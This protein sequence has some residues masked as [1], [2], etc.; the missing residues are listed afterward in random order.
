MAEIKLFDINLEEYRDKI[1][2]LR[3]ELAQLTQDTAE[4]DRKQQE[5]VNTTNALSNAVASSNPSMAQLRTTL[6]DLK[7]EWANAN[8]EAARGA[9]AQQIGVIEGQ[10]KIMNQE[11]KNSSQSAASAEGSYN[12]LAVKM[13]ELQQAA[14]AT[15]DETERLNLSQKANEINQQLKSMDA[16]MGNY[17]RNVGDYASQFAGAMTQMGISLGGA[18]NAFKLASTAG[19]GFRGVL[20]VLRAHPI[21]A[22]VTLLVGIFMKLKDAISKN[23]ALSN[24]WKVAMSAFQP[25]LNAI[26]NAIDWLAGKLV[27][28][29]LWVST[30]LPK[31]LRNVGSFAKGL[32]NI[33]GNIVDAITFIPKTLAKV[34]QA[35]T[36]FVFKGVNAIASKIGD[37]L[38]SVGL[39]DWA[40]KVVNASKSAGEFIKGFYKGVENMFA[41]A[42]DAVRKFGSTIQSALN[43]AG[44]TIEAYQKKARSDIKLEQDLRAEQVKTAESEKKQSK[45]REDIAKASGKKKIELEREL[46]KEIKETGKRQAELAWRQ[47]ESFLAQSKLAPNSKEDNDTLAQLKSAAIAAENA[48]TRASAKIE[49]KVQRQEQ[50][51]ARSASASAKAAQA[52]AEKTEKAVEKAGKAALKT[53]NDTFKQIAEGATTKINE[54][55]SEEELFKS[56]GLLTPEMMRKYADDRYNIQKTSLEREIKLTQDAL[57]NKDILDQDK[58]ALAL[59]Y[60]NLIIQQQAAENK[61][62]SELNKIWLDENKKIYEQNAKNYQQAYAKDNSEYARKNSEDIANISQQYADG[63]ISYEEYKEQ[64]KELQE[65]YDADEADR[66][67]QHL[68]NMLDLK[69]QYLD[70]VLA[71]FGENSEEYLRLKAE[72]DAQEIALEDKKTERIQANAERQAND[73]QKADEI[74][75]NNI[76]KA[77][78]QQENKFKTVQK[79]ANAVTNLASNITNAWK[80]IVQAQLDAGEITEEEAEAQFEKMKTLEIATATV[81]TI[82]GAVGAFMGTWK[83]ETIKPIWLRGVLAGTNAASVLAA[84]IAQIAQIKSTTLDSSGISGNN[85]T[86]ANATP[87]LDEAQDVNQLTSLNV[88]GDS[89]SDSRVYILQSDIVETTNQNKVRV[90]QSTF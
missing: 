73:R 14:K 85:I 17:Q 65:Q 33:L 5:L 10:M 69:K 75:A 53:Y 77:R 9:I 48:A 7:T 28:V 4:Y 43:N 72:Y 79:A 45:L 51:I 68:Q 66:E 31:G 15:S 56:A 34:M 71:Q 59:K 24:K 55:K 63:K 35:V 37:L 40:A 41:G 32:F 26:T 8:S 88:N 58:V 2:Q 3:A 22:V 12:S 1:Q 16:E 76:Q 44:K 67:I 30:N 78:E 19:M 86:V 81:S 39:D 89:G 70:A 36:D 49:Q 18:E 29:M 52:A 23:E 64:L 25:I 74:Q 50:A 42:G 57:N 84:G 6:K 27:D 90:E 21:I 61:H 82:A 80:N 13:R 38:S 60:S 62:K 54:N 87:L 47:Y 11:L 46:Q 83:D 20:D